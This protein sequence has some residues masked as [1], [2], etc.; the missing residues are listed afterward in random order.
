MKLKQTKIE[1]NVME[2]PLPDVMVMI[3]HVLWGRQCSRT[4]K[5]SQFS[6]EWEVS[7]HLR[8]ISTFPRA[9]SIH[10][11]M[12]IFCFVTSHLPNDRNWDS[13]LSKSAELKIRNWRSSN[14][15]IYG[16]LRGSLWKCWDTTSRKSVVSFFSDSLDCGKAISLQEWQVIAN[17]REEMYHNM[18]LNL[19][20]W[21]GDSE[22]FVISKH[23]LLRY[24]AKVIAIKYRFQNAA[25]FACFISAQCTP[26]SNAGSQNQRIYV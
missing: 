8:W 26:E 15:S 21:L 20:A 19:Q 1:F 11:K 14:W 18:W 22:Y 3:N 17:K 2:S 12:L 25:I 5:C 24:I 10:Q 23:R 6:H 9:K 4:S 13:S 16:R 7:I